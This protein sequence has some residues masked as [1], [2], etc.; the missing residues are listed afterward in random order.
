LREDWTH[1]AHVAV[2]AWYVIASPETALDNVR[3]GIKRLN[4]ANGITMTPTGGYLETITV[5]YITLLT[6]FIGGLGEMDPYD[7]AV[8]AIQTFSDQKIL[9][10][11]YT[12]DRLMSAEARYGFIEPDLQPLP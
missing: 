7:R 11:H 1:D 5:A 12:R 10:R 6:A 3:K 8:A 2:A 4:E 9:L